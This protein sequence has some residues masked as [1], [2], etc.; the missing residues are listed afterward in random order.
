VLALAALPTGDGFAKPQ[1]LGAPK[2]AAAAPAP[3]TAKSTTSSGLSPAMDALAST[4]VAAPTFKLGAYLGIPVM[5]ALAV[6]APTRL[7]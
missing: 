1:A 6:T 2:R 7:L 5:D 3:T 4:L